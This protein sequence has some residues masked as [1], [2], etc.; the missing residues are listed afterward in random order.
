MGPEFDIRFCN[1]KK[2]L[3]CLSSAKFPA[4]NF[5]NV[6]SILQ[7][8]QKIPW[9]S[10]SVLRDQIVSRMPSLVLTRLGLLTS[11]V[12]LYLQIDSIICFFPAS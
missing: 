5:L 4:D 8:L 6:F 9:E 2:M 11:N 10:M 7:E 1:I 12:S 3:S